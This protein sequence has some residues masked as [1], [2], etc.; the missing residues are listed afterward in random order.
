[1]GSMYGYPYM[2]YM[3]LYECHM[4]VMKGYARNH[5]HPEGSTIEGYTTEEVVKCYADCIKDG[6][7]RGVLVS[8]HHARL[9]GKGTK[10]V[11]S[12]IDATYKRV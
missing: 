5:A 11:K 12:I 4:V 7:S 8:R 9:S 6:K 1:M 3:Y 10:E 2:H